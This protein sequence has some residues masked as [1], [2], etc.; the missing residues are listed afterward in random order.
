MFNDLEQA[1]ECFLISTESVRYLDYELNILVSLMKI[2]SDLRFTQA[3]AG[4]TVK[5]NGIQIGLRW[6]T[7]MSI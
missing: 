2:W 5:P 1:M 3:T 6:V 7:T 4:E